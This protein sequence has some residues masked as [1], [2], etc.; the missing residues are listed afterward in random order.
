MKT[1]LLKTVQ[2]A[3]LMTIDSS[4]MVSVY[5]SNNFILIHS[6]P[7][8]AFFV[9]VYSQ[10][11]EIVKKQLL[12][13]SVV[14][15]ARPIISGQDLL[16]SHVPYQTVRPIIMP[17]VHVPV[18]NAMSGTFPMVQTDATFVLLT[19]HL[20]LSAVRKQFVQNVPFQCFSIPTP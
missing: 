18:H 10:I 1:D 3:I 2:I 15:L 13:H 7:R 16:V 14:L 20:A 17:Q 5:A 8:F 9:Q 12:G 11:A 19:W 6:V 4:K